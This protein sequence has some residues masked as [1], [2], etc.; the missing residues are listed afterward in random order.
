MLPHIRDADG[1]GA[2]DFTHAVQKFLGADRL[3][4]LPPERMPFLHGADTRLPRRHT[5]GHICR[6]RAQ[7]IEEGGQALAQISEDRDV[8]AHVL[9]EL[10]G[11][12]VK[13]DNACLR[14]K[15]CHCARHAVA[16]ARTDG[17]QQVAV[18]DRHIGGIGAVHPRHPRIAGR[19]GRNAAEPHQCGDGRHPRQGEEFPYIRCRIREDDAAADKE[20]RPLCRAEGVRCRAYGIDIQRDTA[21]V[22]AQGSGSRRG[23]VD[24]CIEHILCHVDDDD[25]GAS[26]PRDEEGLLDHARQIIYVL[27]EVIVL[28]DR[29]RHTDN[30]RLLKG[31]L[32]DIWIGDLPRDADH[33]NGVH[34]RRCNPRHEVRRARSR[35]RKD[36]AD[37]ARGARIA[38]C[39]V[40]G[41]L[42]MAREDMRKFHLIYFIVQREDGTAG[43]AKDD[44][45]ALLP[46][47][48]QK[49]PRSIHHQ[50]NSSFI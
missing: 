23:K 16:E 35:G 45:H 42:F 9:V 1:I 28:R 20:Q 31:V 34:I 7:G 29:C 10:S 48:L 41:A 38:V 33:R 37:L 30:V 2:D 46:K 39:S 21:A 19:I 17:E 50:S 18:L 22:S 36:H 25:T 13:V 12:N 15:L 40:R 3:T 6:R 24:L 47:A 8:G 14:G 32:A 26:R 5:R 11:V 44:L 43:I 4:L 27:D 49:S